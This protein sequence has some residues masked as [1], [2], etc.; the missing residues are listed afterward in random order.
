MEIERTKMEKETDK[1]G[2]LKKK[3]RE[4]SGKREEKGNWEGTIIKKKKG[5]E[6][7]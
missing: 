3:N 1:N 6:L 5:K 2:N 7:R 4:G